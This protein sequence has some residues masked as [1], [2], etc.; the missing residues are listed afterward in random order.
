MSA[1]AV[2]YSYDKLPT[3]NVAPTVGIKAWKKVF[4]CKGTGQGCN[5]KSYMFGVKY[6]QAVL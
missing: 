5:M 4:T 6:L 3:Q 2:S 1:R